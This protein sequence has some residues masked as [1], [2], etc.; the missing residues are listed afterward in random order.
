ML[1]RHVVA[2]P[3]LA[4]DNVPEVPALCS[5]VKQPGAAT[6]P[7]VARFKQLLGSVDRQPVT[8]A[9]EEAAAEEKADALEAADAD[10]IEAA[11]VALDCR[12]LKELAEAWADE[13][14]DALDS[15]E[16]EVSE[17]AAVALDSRALKELAEA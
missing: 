6:T 9:D 11:T 3:N 8:A 17:A 16:A 2:V 15:A 1:V 12:A 14:A 5:W 13:K 7:R 10:V 4:V